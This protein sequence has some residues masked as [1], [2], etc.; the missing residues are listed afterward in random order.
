MKNKALI[1]FLI[2][3]FTSCSKGYKSIEKE[4]LKSFKSIELCNE[5]IKSEN[6]L[7]IEDRHLTELKKLNKNYNNI[8]VF[9]K[10]NDIEYLLR[11]EKNNYYF[12][13]TEIYQSLFYLKN[14]NQEYNLYGI[15]KIN[16]IGELNPKFFE[17]DAFKTIKLNKIKDN[18]YFITKEYNAD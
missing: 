13:D 18:W 8:R 7:I 5:N 15:E 10:E 2:I 6:S 1:T 3:I 4:V 16:E 12:F 17:I 11:K 9:N 14:K